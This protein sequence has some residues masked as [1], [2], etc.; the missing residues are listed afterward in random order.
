MLARLWD[1][2][3]GPPAQPLEGSDLKAALTPTVLWRVCLTGILWCVFVYLP[4]VVPFFIVRKPAGVA[5]MGVWVAAPLISLALMRRGRARAAGW[6]LVVCWWVVATIIVSLSGGVHSVGMGLFMQVI[7][8]AGWL[9]GKRATTYAAALFFAMSL[10]FALLE[11]SGIALPR[12]FPASPVVV[13]SIFFLAA[14]QL[15]VSLTL[16]YGAFGNALAL[17][18]QRAA[19]QSQLAQA[20]QESEDRMRT[21]FEAAPDAVLILNA[22]ARIV[23]ANEAASRQL[24][25]SREE[26]LQLGVEDFV[27]PEFRA[28]AR[29]RFPEIESKPSYESRHLR[30]DGV[31]VPVE[32]NTRSIVYAGRPALMAIARDIS[33]RKKAEHELQVSE[34]RFRTL[35]EN[36]PMA[37]AISHE[38]KVDY[39]NP[40]C[41]RMF[42]LESVEDLRDRPYAEFLAP[43]SRDEVRDRAERRSRGE[44][45]PTH[46]ESIGLRSDGSQFPILLSI[47]PMQFAEGR[48]V[49]AFVADLTEAKRAEEERLRLE[50]QFRQA[51]KL[52]SIGRLAG[53]VAHDFNNLLTVIN[54]YSEMGLGM[55]RDD[56]PLRDC[57]TEIRKAG[58]RAAGL[59]HQLLAFSRKH[60]VE[61]QAVDVNEL[62]LDSYKM[63][64]RVVGE[65]YEVITDLDPEGGQVMADPGQL[66]Q[67]L[68]N[69]VVNARDA[70]PSGGQI[71]LRTSRAQLD[72]AATASFPGASPGPHLVMEVSDTGVGMTADV[73]EKIFDPF[74]T[75]KPKGK[76][77]GLGLSTV[78]GIVQQSGGWI[79]VESQPG[80]GA[81]FRVGLP[82][83]V[84]EGEA[85]VRQAPGEA[86]LEGTETI[87]VVEDQ[88]D[89]RGLVMAVLGEFHYQTLEASSGAEAL[90]MVES[91]HGPI[92]LML[93]DVIMPGMTG[94]QTA[95]RLK[96]L[97]PEMKVL[98][99]SGHA[100][101]VI[102]RRGKL[103][104]GID[105]IA[106]PFTPE[107]LA[108]KIR[109]VLGGAAASRMHSR[110]AA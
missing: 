72:R 87:L 61:P 64:R 98:Y 21:I 17:A 8:F 20:L 96:V 6:V 102:A 37:I 32:L 75:T 109:S 62:I 22:E 36:A 24:G 99:M 19:S 68:L 60:V 104:P 84:Q 103:D 70:M 52:E 76:G 100:D 110:P 48:A 44:P 85:P 55:L 74:F 97:R 79:G 77:T 82:L 10:T 7:V 78:Y 43:Q 88:D 50:Q 23:E 91:H 29:S 1:W 15:T 47:I 30:K 45:V 106:K 18:R 40:M 56:G 105:Y 38:G 31:E 3:S 90:Q 11:H 12:Y 63:L 57:L 9:L 54:G 80:Q 2:I 14:V 101:E 59:T 49:V 26:L 69:L 16:V 92:D 46:Y 35:T 42:G 39:A 67:V 51:Q 65:D 28:R 93:T 83:R 34:A 71:T 108:R 86:Q 25:Y 73:Q 94:K 81:T 66:H 27:A 58:E 41:L 33:E 89:V 4:V 5:L 107:A 13:W 53:G 95:D